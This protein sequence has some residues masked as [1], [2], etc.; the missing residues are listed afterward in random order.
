LPYV[1][2]V[3]VVTP[4]NLL[5]YIK[6]DAENLLKR[7]YDWEPYAQKHF[8]SIMTKFI[9]GYWNP[10]RF[11]F[12]VRRPQFS[13][14]ILTNQMTRNEALEKLKTSP[15]TKEEEQKLFSLVA[16]MLEI[17]ETELQGYM[18][19][20]LWANHYKNSNWMYSIGAKIMFALKMDK[21]IR[22]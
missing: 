4:L 12:D 22:K 17:S 10:K 9:E 14:L 2:G 21:L 13:S 16:R 20:P 6:Q 5:P 18:D 7:E 11:G 3:K 15:M 8:E 1:K 19:M